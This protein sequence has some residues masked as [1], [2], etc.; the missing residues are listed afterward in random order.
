MIMNKYLQSSSSGISEDRIR[1]IID[2][3]AVNDC[4]V[5]INNSAN[6]SIYT[7]L[8]VLQA[9]VLLLVQTEHI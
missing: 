4:S 6:A 1:E 2:E 8:V 7:Q 5:S 9:L 3:T